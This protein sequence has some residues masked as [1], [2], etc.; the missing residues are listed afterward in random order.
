MEKTEH[1]LRNTCDDFGYFP[2]VSYALPRLP[3]LFEEL[4]N[5]EKR[6]TVSIHQISPRKNEVETSI[7]IG[8][9]QTVQRQ[10][11][12]HPDLKPW[13]ETIVG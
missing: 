5:R 13:F 8:S 10:Q 12:S 3:F 9:E 11:H 6:G 4:E 1:F 7:S 2:S